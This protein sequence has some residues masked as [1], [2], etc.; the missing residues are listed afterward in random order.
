MS[1]VCCA[2][3]VAAKTTTTTLAAGAHLN[4]QFIAPATWTGLLQAASKRLIC[5]LVLLAFALEARPQA[6]SQA[7]VTFRDVEGGEFVELGRPPARSGCLWPI[8]ACNSSSLSLSFS[9][10]ELFRYKDPNAN[11]ASGDDDDE[12]KRRWLNK[13]AG[14]AA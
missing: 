8:E 11:G 7:L 9:G 2:T 3:N 12:W 6:Q 10:S 5:A 1:Y 4:L 13:L 14:G